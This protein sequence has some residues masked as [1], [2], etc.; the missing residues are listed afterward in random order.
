MLLKAP[1]WRVQSWRW[2]SVVALGEELSGGRWL[3]SSTL[4]TAR[5]AWRV[6]V[7]MFWRCQCHDVHGK[8]SSEE[9]SSRNL[10]FIKWQS[11]SHHVTV[12]LDDH[13]LHLVAVGSCGSRSWS[14]PGGVLVDQLEHLDVL[15]GSFSFTLPVGH[16]SE[17]L[18]EVGAVRYRTNHLLELRSLDLEGE[19]AH[20][21]LELI[22]RPADQEPGAWSAS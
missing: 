18:G 11:Q 9:R 13:A 12:S 7:I 5:P 4:N 3:A 8:S 16:H 20:G 17:E 22:H 15:A 2:R 10:A 14:N 19:G 1:W 21:G 6:P